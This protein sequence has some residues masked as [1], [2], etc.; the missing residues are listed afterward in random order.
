MILTEASLVVCNSS[1]DKS[2]FVVKLGR[3]IS[4]FNSVFVRAEKKITRNAV[5]QKM[6]C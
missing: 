5:D 1:P 6:K 4:D 2:G 3:N